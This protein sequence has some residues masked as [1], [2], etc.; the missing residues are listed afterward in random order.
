MLFKL[1]SRPEEKPL[2][3][4]GVVAE[5]NRDYPPEA[6]KAAHE[7]PH[8]THEKPSKV[9]KAGAGRGP[10]IRVGQPRKFNN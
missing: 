7:K 4:S 9:P 8:P 10:D 2:V 1:F 3:V 5:V 6:V